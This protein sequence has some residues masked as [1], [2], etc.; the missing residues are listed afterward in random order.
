MIS[1]GKNQVFEAQFRPAGFYYTRFTKT[2]Q[3]VTSAELDVVDQ[4]AVELIAQNQQV[5][6]QY[7][8]LV[9]KNT[10]YGYMSR[11]EVY[12]VKNAGLILG[13][14]T[15]VVQDL[16]DEHYTVNLVFAEHRI[17]PKSGQRSAIRARAHAPYKKFSTANQ[18]RIITIRKSSREWRH[19]RGNGHHNQSGDIKSDS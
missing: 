12:Y 16:G 1:N 8:Y 18:D 14:L 11:T 4:L 5:N 7:V 17:I 10:T 6:E 15:Q 9:L 2:Y 13:K 19:N 3:N